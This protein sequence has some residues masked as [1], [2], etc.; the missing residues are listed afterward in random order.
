MGDDNTTLGDPER[1]RHRLELLNQA[2]RGLLTIHGG[3]IVA[4]LAFLQAVQRDNPSQ[5]R[6]VLVAMIPLVVGLTLAIL[7]MALRYHTSLADQSGNPNWRTI[8]LWSF[9]C[10]YGSVGLFLFSMLYLIFS[11][12]CI[13]HE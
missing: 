7:F 8:R 11:S 13:C 1:T 3:A 5:A 10:L 12:L 2:Y 6:V 9:V 4:L